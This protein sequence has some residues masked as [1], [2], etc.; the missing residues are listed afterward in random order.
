[1]RALAFHR[2]GSGS[3]PGLDAI[4]GL[5]L[6]L[7]LFSAPRGFSPGTPVFH[8]PQKLT[9][10]NSNSMQISVDEEPLCGGAPADSRY[11]G[12]PI[13]RT[14]RGNTIWFEK[15]GVREIEGG[16][17]LRLIGRVLYE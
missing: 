2:C 5:S 13:S 3:I 16:I 9:F 17:K 1:M 8:S 15:S 14:S 6:L 4:C 7:V 11:S 10:P 12:I